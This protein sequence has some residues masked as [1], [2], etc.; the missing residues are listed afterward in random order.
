MLLKRLVLGR[1]DGL[2]QMRRDLVVADDRPPFDGEVADRLAAHVN[3]PGDRA[4]RVVVKR[5]DL[6]QVSGRGKEQAAHRPEGSGE[7]EEQGHGRAPRHPEDVMS[8]W[9]RV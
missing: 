3:E 4:R 9:E 8:H 6:R 2:A 1:D 7:D 5:G